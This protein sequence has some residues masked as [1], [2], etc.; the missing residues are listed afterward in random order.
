MNRILLLAV[1]LLL[2]V[3]A[4]AT[5]IDFVQGKTWKEILAQAK[6][7]NKLIFLD[8][9]ATWCGPCKYLQKNVFTDEKVGQFYNQSFLNVK[10]DMEEGEGVQL[11][12]DLGVQSYPTLFFINGDGEVVHKKIGA[13]E[14]DAF[15]QLGT[16]ATNP[17]KQ[18]YSVRKKALAGTLSPSAFHAWVHEAGSMD[19]PGLE[20]LVAGYLHGKSGVEPDRDLIEL[21]LDHA[22]LDGP[23]IQKLQ[24][25]KATYALRIGR[26]L[27][28]YDEA[29]LRRV[30]RH[31]L[32]MAAA[33]DTI[34]FRTLENTVRKYF[35]A[36]A[37]TETRKLKVV[38]YTQTEENK[39]AVGELA[40]LVSMPGLRAAELSDL[41]MKHYRLIAS[42]NR[43]PD[44]ITRVNKYV[45]GPKDTGLAYHKNLA[46]LVLYYLNGDKTNMKRYSDL[47]LK[48]KAAPDE[49]KE[50]AGKLATKE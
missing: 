1:F 14:A 15:L 6:K 36:Q 12:K 24:Q 16:D 46:L 35:P 27:P 4:S 8:A 49:V 7:E 18:Y 2:S 29:L 28:D 38:Y 22:L 41:V 42:E 20:G 13:M 25:N 23:G 45:L 34:N 5:G 47:I 50:T 17:D 10:M 31:G 37:G 9:Y 43:L 32:E 48:D 33:G 26:S 11:A 44:F 40:S 39:R 3:F 30:L 21:M 19:E